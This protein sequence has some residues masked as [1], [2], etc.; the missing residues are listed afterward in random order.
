M[1]DFKWFDLISGG[2]V[3]ARNICKKIDRQA[4]GEV[5]EMVVPSLILNNEQQI[6]VI[7]HNLS[8]D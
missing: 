1:I 7:K 4:S 6:H 5:S 8:V 2:G 3:I